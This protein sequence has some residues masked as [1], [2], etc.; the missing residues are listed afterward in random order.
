MTNMNSIITLKDAF[1]DPVPWKLTR[2]S[3]PHWQIYVQMSYVDL[4]I[5]IDLIRKAKAE[6]MKQIEEEKYKQ[7]EKEIEKWKLTSDKS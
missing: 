2:W 7:L 3:E 6:K 5:I 1:E 4:D